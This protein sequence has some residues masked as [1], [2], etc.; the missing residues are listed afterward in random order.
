MQRKLKIK[1]CGLNNFENIEQVVK[2]HPDF[3]GF[4]FYEKSPRYLTLKSLPTIPEGIQR[5]GV[6]VNENLDKILNTYKKYDL[7]FVQLHGNETPDFCQRLVSKN[8]KIIKAFNIQSEK[9]DFQDI[10]KY[11]DFCEYF[12]FDAKSGGSGESFSWTLL[13]N[14][15]SP[16]PFL[17]AG[18]I[19]LKNLTE[20]LSLKHPQLIGLDLNSCWEIQP[21][22]KNI[23]LLKI[24][25]Q[26]IKQI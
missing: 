11:A 1:I 22:L 5:V 4:I 14:Y 15:K 20:D 25:F 24:G 9:F 17:L 6:F 13:E 8:V 19:G 12:L 2:L 26:K 18:G 16:I 3:V 7:D 23:D 10:N 21:G